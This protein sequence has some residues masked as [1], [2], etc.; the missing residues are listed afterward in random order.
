M[1]WTPDDQN[2][3]GQALLGS[4]PGTIAA[5]GR[6]GI[7]AYIA[8]LQARGL[9]AERVLMAIRTWP[10]ASDFPP[11]APN[12][13]AAARRDPSKPTF[14]EA[15]ELIRRALRAW[16]RPLTGD[17]ANEAEL[18]RARERM[19][20]ERAE[21]VHPLVASF[22]AR[23]RIEQ[24]QKELAELGDEEWGSVRRRD[25][26][27]AWEQHCEAF[28]GRE[29]AALATG[30]RDGL[31]RLDPLATLGVRSPIAELDPSTEGVV[32]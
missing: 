1:T 15:L 8:E 29:T 19:V 25:L 22:I 23:R 27:A 6:E 24:L 3:V 21:S 10:A 16:N 30:R 14:D 2:D 11:S 4:W 32:S 28:E 31:R 5:W 20:M 9:S 13:A 17:Y 18:L 26:Q 12:L 7:A